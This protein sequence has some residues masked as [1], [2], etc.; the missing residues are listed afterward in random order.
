M[1][2]ILTTKGLYVRYYIWNT[3]CIVKTYNWCIIIIHITGTQNAILDHIIICYVKSH[4]NIQKCTFKYHNKK[5]KK[6][7][8]TKKNRRRKYKIEVWSIF[9]LFVFLHRVILIIIYSPSVLYTYKT[10]YS[11]T[12]NVISKTSLLLS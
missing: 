11:R 9:I 3:L 12:R 1:N 10:T 2:T 8:I 4:I 7:L 5:K 6:K